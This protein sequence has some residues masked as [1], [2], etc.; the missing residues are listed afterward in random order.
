MRPP[1]SLA[2]SHLA[3]V[4]LFSLL[5][6]WS[7]SALAA[8][9]TGGAAGS[10]LLGSAGSSS[11]GATGGSG[12]ALQGT[13]G[14]AAGASTQG[15]TGGTAGASAQGGSGAAGASPASAMG[16]TAG[17]GAGAGGSGASDA[18]SA[19]TS[20]IPD[21]RS[22][23][24]LGCSIHEPGEGAPS[25]LALASLLGLTLGGLSR[26]R[27]R[28]LRM[29]ALSLGA[30]LGIAALAE[31]QHPKPKGKPLH[32]AASAP[33]SGS[34]SASASATA[35][36]SSMPDLSSSS[37]MQMLGW[38]MANAS[39]SASTQGSAEPPP[40]PAWAQPTGSVDP[41]TQESP[42]PEKSSEFHSLVIEYNPLTILTERIA[43]TLLFMPLE[44]HA[45]LLSPYYVLAVTN[46][47]RPPN[48]VNGFGAELGYQYFTGVLGPRGFYYGPS[49]LFFAGKLKA[50]S[51]GASV[52]FQSFGAAFDVGYQAIFGHL[53]I[54]LGAGAQFTFSTKSLGNQELPVSIYTNTFLRP[55]A[56]VDIGYAFL[57]LSPWQ[58]DV[59]E[60]STRVMRVGLLLGPE[61]RSIL[62]ENPDGVRSLL[63]EVHPEDL[64]DVVAELPE[65]EA[66]KI[67][68]R[69]SADDAATILERLEDDTQ[70]AIVEHMEPASVAQIAAEMAVDDRGELLDA[71]DENVGEAV[72]AN[73]ERIDPEAAKEVEQR[74]QWPDNSAGRLMVLDYVS[75]PVDAQVEDGI[76]AIRKAS[77]AESVNYVYLINQSHRLMGVVSLRELLLAQPRTPLL[78]LSFDNLIS[79]H[80]TLDQEEVARQM[81]KYDLTALPVVRD[82]GT[83]LGIITVDDIIDVLTEEQTEDAQKFGAVEP[84]E[85]SYFATRFWTFI[86]KRASW[87][88]ALFISEFFTGSALRHYD[89]VIQ[90]VTTLSF[91]VPLLIS[92]GGNSGGQS[93]SLIIRGMAVGEVKL[94]DWWRVLI[95]E[96]GQGIVL[97]LILA[98][99]GVIRVFMWG[100][101]IRFAIVIGFT[102]IGITTMGCTV[103][104]MLPLTLK[105]L[106]VDPATSSAPFI[107]SLVDVLGLIIYFNIAKL[108]LADVIAHAITHAS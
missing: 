65:Q 12:G 61:L 54:G 44:H 72:F 93:T 4:A 2:S 91:Y 102:L 64:A 53:L 21:S 41:L 62:R 25:W 46:N 55:R 57:G 81:A 37:E 73:L 39:A 96:S 26:R 15:T 105:R 59:D 50:D 101:G 78:E 87:L 108:I 99:V 56:F 106:G 20:A 48:Y 103:G 70:E 30:A 16:G 88:L 63:E 83:M 14:G 13:T 68:T 71:L 74:E 104:S 23:D 95:R 67:L 40:P 49:L 42:L 47:P 77:E 97:G 66:A 52:D 34:S 33:A 11:Q 18:G 80:P 3:A 58:S 5:L 17:A 85:D 6:G 60:V 10:S 90:A 35:S 24:N 29:A 22:Y 51:T 38:A 100:D 8:P 76:A 79:V 86:R 94:S 98:T 92:T 31:A 89:N 7:G 84:L 1:S 75:T 19:G 43:A 32:G 36:D 82:D 28:S 69:I 9:G 27:K 45:L 107:A